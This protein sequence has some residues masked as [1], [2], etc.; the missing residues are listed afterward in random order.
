MRKA[1]LEIMFDKNGQHSEQSK[2]IAEQNELW[3]EKEIITWGGI[4]ASDGVA[5]GEATRGRL[6]SSAMSGTERAITK[7][8]SQ[9]E[10]AIESVIPSQP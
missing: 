7:G 4:L 8:V 6:P 1:S 3:A 2:F 9:S 5:L 10:K